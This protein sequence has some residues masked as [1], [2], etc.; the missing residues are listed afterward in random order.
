MRGHVRKRGQT[1]EVMLELGEQPVQR[2]PV[3]LDR[4]GRAK[5]HWTDRGRL[6]ACPT[7]GGALDADHGA[8]PISCHPSA[9]APRRKPRWP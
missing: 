4:R 8:S 2:C 9:T 7:C 6:E 1:W 5:R 3:C